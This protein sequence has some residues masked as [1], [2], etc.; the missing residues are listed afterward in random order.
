MLLLYFYSRSQS[1]LAIPLRVLPY[2]PV[3]PPHISIIMA[4][5]FTKNPTSLLLIHFSGFPLSK[6]RHC[7]S[8]SISSGM[9]KF[10]YFSATFIVY[11]ENTFTSDQTTLSHK[12]RT[13]S[14]FLHSKYNIQHHLNI[15]SNDLI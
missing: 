5:G 12:H 10:H 13:L 11:L 14:L 1:I 3:F 6:Y 15:F 8:Q 9:L 2:F 7:L 4:C